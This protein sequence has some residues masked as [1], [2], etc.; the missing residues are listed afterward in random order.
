MALPGLTRGA[1]DQRYG[2]L[3]RQRRYSVPSP[4][5]LTRSVAMTSP[6][7]TVITKSTGVSAVTIA[8]GGTGYV[9][10]DTITVAG[11]TFATPAVLTVVTVSAGVITSV[12]VKTPGVYTLGSTPTNP[13]SQAS[14]SGSGTGATFTLTFN[15]GVGCS[16]PNALGFG[17]TNAAFRFTGTGPANIG[18]SGYYGNSALNGVACLWEWSTDAP[19]FDIRLL[20]Q[21]GFFILYCNGQRVTDAGWNTDASGAPYVL[22]VNFGGSAQARTFKL[23][24][25]N[26]AFNGVSVGA[27][28]SVWLPLE[29]RRPLAW[30]LGDS[31]AFGTNATSLALAGIN[32]MCEMLGIE[33]IPD[34][35][36]GSGWNTTGTNLVTTRVSARLA[37]L[38][39]VP[40]YVFLDLGY[41]DAG[42][43]MTTLA[44]NFAAAVAAIKAA[45][46]KAKIICFGPATPLGPT[47]NLTTVQTTVS[48]LC[49]TAGITFIDVSGFITAANGFGVYTNTGDS[50]H[51]TQGGYD[52]L[53][54]RKAQAVA[55][56][57]ETLVA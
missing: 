17:G 18:S 9:A 5:N 41:N 19:Q 48:G 4:L 52:Y 53:A 36:G 16:L 27:A 54:A 47:T 42:G 3:L 22:T 14:T 37:A 55:H 51:P 31:Y 50:T 43:N 23:F 44:T 8:G 25:V 30:T 40:E 49:A 24:A 6:P 29:A 32:S 26:S 12:A 34:G 39:H 7:T 2:N 20:G 57:L 56:A 28:N 1:A 21:A 13:V 11:G 15:A 35:V 46:P 10:L 38:T 45:V 33:S